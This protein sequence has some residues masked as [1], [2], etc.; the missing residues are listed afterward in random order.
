M[1]RIYAQ[2][3]EPVWETTASLAVNA[4][5]SGSAVCEGMAK[6]VGIAWANAS[7]NAS[8]FQIWQ[9]SNRGA[10]WDYVTNYTI[11]PST[12]SAFSVDIVGNA[13]KVSCSNGATAASLFRAY[14]ALRPI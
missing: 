13:V 6:L 5:V 4:N 3:I 12:A 1:S 11:S 14:F 2:A 8:K 7:T 9:S 10:N